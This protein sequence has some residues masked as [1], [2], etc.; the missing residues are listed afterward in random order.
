MAKI[1]VVEDDEQ[2]LNIIGRWLANEHHTAELI[3]EGEE[4]LFRLKTYDYD[5]V[6]LDW[7]LPD[8][9]GI[10]VVKEYRGHK[11]KAPMLMLTARNTIED[12][13]QGLDTGADDYLTKPFHAKELIARVNSLLRRPTPATEVAT[14]KLGEIELD[15][16]TLK[17]RTDGKEL[18]L[19]PREF[20]LLEFLMR[21]PGK[22]H[23]N[24]HL[25]SS[26]WPDDDPGATPEALA[27]CVRR[28]RKKFEQ[29]ESLIRNVHGE[30]YGLF[31]E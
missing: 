13:V 29:G 7:G 4:A 30:G 1:L 8:M 11:G 2:L 15:L 18:T 19:S 21:H 25:L 31:I 6:I 9:Q 10:D 23:S 26:V 5:L 3:V 17:A 22:I 28:L 12:R 20:A 16:R 27:T 24:E 14:L